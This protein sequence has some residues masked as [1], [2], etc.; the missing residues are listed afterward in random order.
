[1]KFKKT[2]LAFPLMVS[3]LVLVMPQAG[4]AGP[5]SADS[6]LDS[7]KKIRVHARYP[8]D[9]VRSGKNHDKHFVER[10]NWFTKGSFWGGNG[11][12]GLTQGCARIDVPHDMSDYRN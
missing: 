3:A 12:L 2:L 11:S 6:S 8:G 9:Y 1:M 7:Q 4:V 5:D 10:C